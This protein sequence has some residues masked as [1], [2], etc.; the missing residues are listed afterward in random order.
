MPEGD[1]IRRLAA[2]FDE[3]FVGEGVRASSPQGRFAAS[4]AR[5]DGAVL[6]RVRVHGKHMFMGFARPGAEGSRPEQWVHIHLGLYGW[7]RFN[8]DETLVDEGHGVAHRIPDVPSGQW[9]GHSETRWGEG[10]GT[11]EAGAWE[12]PEPV[13]QVR[14]RLVNDHAVADLVG[15]NRCELITDEEREAVEARLGPDPLEPGARD[16]ARA[17]ERFASVAHAKRR[18]IGEIVMDQSIIA[19]VGNIYRADALFLAGISPHRKGTNVSVKRLEDLWVLICDLMNRGLAAG[20]LETMDPD[21][22][23]VPPIEGDQEASRWYVYHRTGRPCLRCGTPIREA[24]MQN[25][26]LFWCPSCQ[27]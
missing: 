25:R 16:D 6:E 4:A 10:Y 5:L 15:P 19:G 17:R 11:A 22:A 21:E 13:G 27:R 2:T 14:L 20:R 24:L 3:L 12:P 26:R 7:W 23:P 18:A 9:N 8:G 1:A